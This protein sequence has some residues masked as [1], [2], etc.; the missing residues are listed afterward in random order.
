MVCRITKRAAPRTCDAQ[1][2]PD[3]SASTHIGLTLTDGS[4]LPSGDFTMTVGVEGVT[5]RQSMFSAA[6][7]SEHCCGND[8]RVPW[9]A[10]FL[11]IFLLAYLHTP[12]AGGGRGTAPP[13]FATLASPAA[14]PVPITATHSLLLLH[15]SAYPLPTSCVSYRFRRSAFKVS[16]RGKPVPGPPLT[17]HLAGITQLGLGTSGHAGKF[18]LTIASLYA[19]TKGDACAA[20][21]E[22]PKLLLG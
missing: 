17:K 15:Y 6:L 20:S 1:V 19:T 7:T 22:A 13:P 21:A 11:P 3:A 4:G 16:F 10:A 8:C 14:T 18:S 9:S 5:T 12:R 2:F